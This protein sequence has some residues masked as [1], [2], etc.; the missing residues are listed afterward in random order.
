LIWV[1]SPLEAGLFLDSRT[2]LQRP[3]SGAMYWLTFETSG[4]VQVRIV[5]ANHLLLARMKAGMAGQKGA[6]QEGHQL[7]AKTAG[8]IPEKMVGRSLSQKEATALLKQ[9]A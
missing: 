3:I 6:F 8:K 5:Q 4:D 9:I 1:K 7:D 2:A